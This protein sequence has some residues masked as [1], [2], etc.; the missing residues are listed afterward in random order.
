MAGHLITP[1]NH[2]W[3]FFNSYSLL[4]S[5]IWGYIF[6]R[7][8]RNEKIRATIIIFLL[9]EAFVA[10]YLFYSNGIRSRFFTEFVCVNSLLQI[11]WVL[12]SFYERY[13]RDEILALEKEPMFWYCLGILM[14]APTTYFLFVYFD[15]I[16]NG[17]D[18][19]YKNLWSIHHLLNTFMYLI[20]TI[21]ILTNILRTS[22]FRN[23]SISYKS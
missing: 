4:D 16:R 19:N 5:L 9:S 1:K 7:N 6:Y 17:N 11:L 8:S 22:K 23:V 10:F 18:L 13:K 20:F 15:I 14:Y 3:I 21:G 2:V 12:S